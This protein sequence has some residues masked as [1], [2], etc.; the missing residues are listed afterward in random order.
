MV[1]DGPVA[2]P[3]SLCIAYHQYSCLLFVSSGLWGPVGLCLMFVP[4]R[5]MG[6]RLGYYLTIFSYLL[7]FYCY[8]VGF[9]FRIV[10]VCPPNTS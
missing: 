2:H 8:L 7:L 5:L 3:T 4:S 1:L 9:D 6:V 10:V